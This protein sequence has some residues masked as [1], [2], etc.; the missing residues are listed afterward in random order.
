MDSSPLNKRERQ[1]QNASN[2]PSEGPAS[3]R[4]NTN[5]NGTGVDE[6]VLAS[7]HV[8]RS[9]PLAALAETAKNYARSA[10]ASNTRRAYDAD[11]R[12]F[13]SWLRRQGLPQLPPDPQTVGLYLA[14]CADGAGHGAEPTSVA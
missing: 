7:P 1:D 12:H 5:E 2:D 6:G 4:E 10:R 8:A 13:S 14:A 9:G 11:W 3:S